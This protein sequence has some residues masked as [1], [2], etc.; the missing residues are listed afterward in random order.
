MGLCILNVAISL[1]DVRRTKP[2]K[3]DKHVLGLQQDQ[4]KSLKC[5]YFKKEENVQFDLF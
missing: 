5:R 1:V 2:S 3:L 4:Q